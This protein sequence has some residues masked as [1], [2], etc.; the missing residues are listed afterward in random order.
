MFDQA[1]NSIEQQVRGGTVRALCGDFV[2]SMSY[3]DGAAELDLA[4]G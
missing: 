2:A 1:S 4:Q 3:M